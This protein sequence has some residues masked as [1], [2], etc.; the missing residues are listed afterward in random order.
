MSKNEYKSILPNSDCREFS[1][2]LYGN[3]RFCFKALF[4]FHNAKILFG[5]FVDWQFFEGSP[6][7]MESTIWQF[8]ISPWLRLIWSDL[9][10]VASHSLVGFVYKSLVKTIQTGFGNDSQHGT[11]DQIFQLKKYINSTLKVP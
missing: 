11:S 9:Y 8:P 1:T 3:F 4:P 7:K 2:D 10:H 6:Y 5:F